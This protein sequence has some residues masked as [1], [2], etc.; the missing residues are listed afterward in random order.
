MSLTCS[1]AAVRYRAVQPYCKPS[2]VQ[3]KVGEKD[4][5][6]TDMFIVF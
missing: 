1:W 5:G 2:K 4:D 3:I 6:V